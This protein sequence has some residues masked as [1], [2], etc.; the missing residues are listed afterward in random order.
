MSMTKQSVGTAINHDKELLTENEQ[1][2]GTRPFSLY[3]KNI[4]IPT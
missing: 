1:T 2:I 4:K 3:L